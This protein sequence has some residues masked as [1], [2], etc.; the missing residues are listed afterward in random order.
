M[1]TKIQGASTGMQPIVLFDGKCN[2]CQASVRFLIRHNRSGNL[3]FCPIQSIHGSKAISRGGISMSSNTL[4]LVQDNM[5]YTYSTAALKITAHLCFPWPMA[6]VFLIIPLSVRDSI[7][8]F[9]ARKRYAWF[10]MSTFCPTAASD[11]TG[12][13]LS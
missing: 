12:R 7:Y 13:F 3:R 11:Q 10:G 6:Q 1:T 4:M 2:L 9:I 5:L 8:R